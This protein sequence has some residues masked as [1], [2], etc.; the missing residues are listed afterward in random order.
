M[1]VRLFLHAEIHCDMRS[2]SRRICEKIF[3]LQTVFFPQLFWK[4]PVKIKKE[5]ASGVYI[6]KTF[7]RLPVFFLPSAPCA[8]NRSK[9]LKK[10]EAARFVQF[11]PFQIPLP[12]LQK[13][14]FRRRAPSGHITVGK[15]RQICHAYP[16]ASSSGIII[17]IYLFHI[18]D[19]LCREKHLRQNPLLQRHCIRSETGRSLP[20]LCQHFY[21]S[22]CMAAEIAEHYVIIL[23]MPECVERKSQEKRIL[24]FS[25]FRNGIA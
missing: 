10:T 8:G 11:L 2:G 22:L 12:D 1:E 7:R 6:K 24:L 3:I 18:R 5:S 25:I 9:V 16:L 19:I 14:M 20:D 23:S 17:F 21:R 13:Y 4:S 15:P